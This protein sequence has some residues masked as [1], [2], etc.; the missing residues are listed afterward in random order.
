MRK[1]EI[2][3]NTKETSIELSLNL[4]G[5]GAADID[6]G[7]GFYDHMLGHIAHHGKFDLRVQAS[8]DLHIDAHH[9]IEDIAICLGR[10]IDEA[11]ASRS[12]I[13][14]M[15]AAYVPMDEAL[16]RAVIDLSGRPY[17]VIEAGF[18]S[19][20]L[21]QM[22]SDLVAHAF[23][24]IAAQAKMNLHCQVL[25]GRNDHHKAEA[26]FKAFGRALA[27]A[28]AVDPARIGVPSTKG[29]LTE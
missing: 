6:S 10:A 19:P 23:E 8:G 12:G 9:T 2:K 24:S 27:Q 29:T 21:G 22:P 5:A 3:R 14:R 26:L 28:V 4:D 15:G 7:I 20:L 11:L 13:Q 1:A 18:Q 16:A 25:Y 17:A